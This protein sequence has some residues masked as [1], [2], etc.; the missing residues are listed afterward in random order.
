MVLSFFNESVTVK[1]A[2]IIEKN[3]M[4][5]RDW[6]NATEHTISGVLITPQ[7]TS[8]DFADRTGQQT[9]RYNFRT[10]F[11]ADIEPGDRIEW[12][13][14]CYEIDGEVFR[15]KSPTGRVSSTRCTLVRW[16]G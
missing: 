5:Y 13:G 9:N 11:S 14:E 15:T 1:R 10:N 8:Q 12:L 2:P 4:E 3:F 16:E 6:S 7:S